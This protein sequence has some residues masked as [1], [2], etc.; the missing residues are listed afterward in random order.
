MTLHA[1]LVVMGLALCS[2]GA[3]SECPRFSSSAP[4]IQCSDFSLSLEPNTCRQFGN[5]CAANREWATSAPLDAIRLGGFDHNG[6]F[7]EDRPASVSIRTER[8]A[9][10]TTRSICAGAT[11]IVNESL[12]FTY[13]RG[14]GYGTGHLTLTVSPRLALSIS[15]TPDRI[16][17]GGS[18]QLVA[19]VSGGVPPYS[20]SWVPLSGLNPTNTPIPLASPAVTTT[21]PLSVTDAAGQTIT[22]QVTVFVNMSLRV[23]ANPPRIDPGDVSQLAASA[24]GGSLPYSFEWTP[25]DSLDFAD[26]AGPLAAPSAT[27]TYSV[28]VTDA[29]GSTRHGSVTVTLMSLDVTGWHS[30]LLIGESTTMTAVVQGGTPPYVFAWSPPEG[31]ADPTNPVQTVAP[32]APTS[33]QVTVTDATG[34]SATSGA[35]IHAGSII[36]EATP[37]QSTVNVGESVQLGVTVRGGT[38]PF[39]FQWSPP[40][41]L[42]DPTRQDPVASPSESTAYVAVVRDNTGAVATS[43]AH[44]NVNLAVRVSA[45]PPG[46]TQGQSSQLLATAEGGSGRYRYSWSPLS[47][48]SDPTVADPIA[49]P[50]ATTTYTVVVTDAGNRTTT[51]QVTVAV[52]AISPPPAAAFS[53]TG[54][55]FTVYLD[56][57]TSTG[58]IASYAWDLSWTAPTPD[59]VGTTPFTT[60]PF[61]EGQAGTITL[62][63]TAVDGRT[64]SVTRSYP[65]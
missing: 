14:A 24:F 25:A 32:S 29:T 33:Y 45:V 22:G 2:I 7:I 34:A 17:G 9:G 11:P 63:V 57:S 49:S 12:V 10:H 48:L 51:G 38:P 54:D 42:D 4:S 58:N 30:P 61:V 44:V 56:A 65:R 21:Y 59:M 3:L 31:M 6:I 8:S 53:W 46:I 62:T 39:T 52:G 40:D 37:R 23:S 60:F 47:A 50:I 26:I 28:I 20:Y 1:R 18:S 55:P 19:T 27:T 16:D 5:P 15:A 35:S 64:A 43:V 13:A 36:V 41:S